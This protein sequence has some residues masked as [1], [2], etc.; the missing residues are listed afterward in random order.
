MGKSFQF[1]RRLLL[2]G[3]D[4][5]KAV[6]GRTVGPHGLGLSAMNNEQ[7]W[8]KGNLFVIPD[9]EPPG[10]AVSFQAHH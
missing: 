2:T 5:W 7:W 4:V 3:S 6:L 10:L 8:P 1:V 9:L